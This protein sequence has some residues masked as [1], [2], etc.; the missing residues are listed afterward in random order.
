MG[1]RSNYSDP[2]A[3]TAIGN[4]DRARRTAAT[5]KPVKQR[6]GRRLLAEFPDVFAGLLPHEAKDVALKAHHLAG[7]DVWAITREHLEQA[8][9]AIR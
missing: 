5:L 9:A 8:K 1:R 6:Q 3:S 2:T 7:N 4:V